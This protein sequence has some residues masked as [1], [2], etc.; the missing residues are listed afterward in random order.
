VRESLRHSCGSEGEFQKAERTLS[1]GCQALLQLLDTDREGSSTASSLA[2]HIRSCPLCH[3]GIVRL[4][5]A[6]LVRD[7]LNCDQCRARFPAYYE[8]THPEYPLVQMSE[9]EMREVVIHLG[10]CVRCQEEYEELVKLWRME[11]SGEAFET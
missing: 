7:V 10:Q 2:A 9:E 11:E 3:R 6:L 5:R 8:A 1:I 4:S